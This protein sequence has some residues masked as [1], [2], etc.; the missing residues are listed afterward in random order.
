M[1][2]HEDPERTARHFADQDRRTRGGLDRTE[3]LSV[4]DRWLMESI[5]AKEDLVVEPKD[6]S[7]YTLPSHAA[8]ILPAAAFAEIGELLSLVKQANDEMQGTRSSVAHVLLGGDDLVSDVRRRLRAWADAYASTRL[9]KP[10]SRDGSEVA[11]YKRL[12]GEL[13]PDLERIAFEKASVHSAFLADFT[14]YL[15]WAAFRATWASRLVFEDK[16]S[17]H[18][19]FAIRTDSPIDEV[20]CQHA[21]QLYGWEKA[22]DVARV[23]GAMPRDSG[24]VTV[25]SELARDRL[26]GLA[27]DIREMRPFLIR[28]SNPVKAAVEIAPGLFVTWVWAGG[29]AL[30]QVPVAESERE[31]IEQHRKRRF[32]TM[33]RVGYDGILASDATPWLDATSAGGR[34]A[35]AQNLRIVEAIHAKLFSV[36]ERVDLDAVYRTAR[37][38]AESATS[39]VDAL[40]DE[41]VAVTCQLAP[42]DEPTAEVGAERPRIYT[43]RLERLLNVLGDRLGCE[44]RQGKGSEVVVYRPGGKIARLGRH[45][46]NREVPSALVRSVLERLGVSFGEWVAAMR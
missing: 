44:V 4:R 13:L 43:L 32:R 38:S 34:R 45:T 39:A 22:D 7:F 2:D 24:A 23:F 18:S 16:A 28:D 6:A 15:P 27:S 12:V 36:Y 1:T 33:L 17:L 20:Y 41:N 31:V 21:V 25:G 11:R 19:R 35:L 40:T 5:D 10:S 8:K 46:R 9:A 14:D 3:N 26:G 42:V 30:G 37:D 29:Q